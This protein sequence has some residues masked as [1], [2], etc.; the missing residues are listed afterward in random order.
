MD[1]A[2]S[3]RT[4]EFF[5][6][7]LLNEIREQNWKMHVCIAMDGGRIRNGTAAST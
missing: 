4:G 1:G 6:Q 7:K 5:S 3:V 2:L